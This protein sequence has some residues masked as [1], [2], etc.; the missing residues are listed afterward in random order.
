VCQDYPKPSS[1]ETANDA[2]MDPLYPRR[3]CR[4]SGSDRWCRHSQAVEPAANRWPEFARMTEWFPALLS[5]VE[6]R[7]SLSRR[8]RGGVPEQSGARGSFG[9]AQPLLGSGVSFEGRLVGRV[10]RALCGQQASRG[11][12]RYSPGADEFGDHRFVI[13]PNSPLIWLPEHRVPPAAIERQSRIHLNH[14]ANEARAAQTTAQTPSD[15]RSSPPDDVP[16]IRPPAA[17]Y[18]ERANSRGRCW[19]PGGAAEYRHADANLRS[20]APPVIS[21]RMSGNILIARYVY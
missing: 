2:L 1:R 15:R 19:R 17:S 3:V 4:P 21:I 5:I 7:L 20:I 18:T 11:A 14:A 9:L 13:S 8:R 10:N 16:R 6:L 12:A